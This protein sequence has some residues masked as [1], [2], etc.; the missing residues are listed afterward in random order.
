MILGIT[1]LIAYVLVA[2]LLSRPIYGVISSRS[3][4]NYYARWGTY[5]SH[6]E[7]NWIRYYRTEC[8]LGSLLLSMIWPLLGFIPVLVG[9][10][11]WMLGSKIRP[12]FEIERE[13]EKMQRR[14]RELEK[15]LKI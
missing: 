13:R 6:S 15:E 12:N 3:K 4:E 8:V 14:I 10:K 7:Q 9:M 11:R 2:V 1:I 5:S